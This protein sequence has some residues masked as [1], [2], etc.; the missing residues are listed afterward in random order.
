MENIQGDNKLN[1]ENMPL[2]EVNNNKTSINLDNHIREP[3]KSQSIRVGM[4][5]ELTGGDTIRV[6]KYYE[7]KHLYTSIE[8][9]INIKLNT[10]E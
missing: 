2:V 3:D 5:K 10:K 6:C 9:F 7:N 1:N 8:E 4:S